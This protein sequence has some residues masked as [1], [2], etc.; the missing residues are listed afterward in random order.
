MRMLLGMVLLAGAFLGGYYFGRQPGSPD[1]FGTASQVMSKIRQ[2]GG[3]VAEVMNNP[4]VSNFISPSS[5]APSQ[6]GIVQI[7][8]KA[9]QVGVLP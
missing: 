8:G 7:N 9:Y 6:S 5:S 2:T 4:S 1:I 3:T